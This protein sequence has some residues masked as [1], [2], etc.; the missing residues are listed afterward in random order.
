MGIAGLNPTTFVEGML[1]AKAQIG[2]LSANELVGM[3][4]KKFTIGGKKLRISV[5]ET[6]KPAV[7]LGKRGELCDDMNR[8]LSDEKLDDVI[9]FVVDVLNEAST[10]LT[11]TKSAAAVVENA[12]KVK[13]SSDGT[14]FLPGVLSRKKQ[15][16]PTLE[17]AAKAED[18]L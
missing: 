11:C 8:R 5:L 4:S 7:P 2:H 16:I 13:A 14:H 15:M 3:D 12:W 1:D 10:V 17:K 9:M 6:T 18:E